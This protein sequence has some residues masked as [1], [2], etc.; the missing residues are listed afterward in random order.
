MVIILKKELL[1]NVQAL[2]IEKTQTRL[3]RD[4]FTRLK[5]I[6]LIDKYDAYQLFDDEWE[7]ISGDLE[8]ILTEGFK[9]TK[10]VE[11]NMVI[12]KKSR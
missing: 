4:V 5:D 11:A 1:D 3:S 8:I 9:A 12:K 6:S 10:V 7:K 2:N